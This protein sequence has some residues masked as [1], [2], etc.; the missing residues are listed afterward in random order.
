MVHAVLDMDGDGILHLP[1][2]VAAM[3]AVS[4]GEDGKAT[5]RGTSAAWVLSKDSRRLL[6]SW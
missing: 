4:A 6:T 3:A 1:D 5:I 2:D